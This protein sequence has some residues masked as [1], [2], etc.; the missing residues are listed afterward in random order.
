MAVNNS[1]GAFIATYQ[2]QLAHCPHRFS[3][4]DSYHTNDIGGETEAPKSLRSHSFC[5]LS[6]DNTHVSQA[7]SLG[8]EV[9]CRVLSYGFLA[10]VLLCVYDR[11]PHVAQAGIELVILPCQP[12]KSWDDRSNPAQP[13]HFLHVSFAI[14]SVNTTHFSHAVRT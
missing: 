7:P 6:D 9:L 10:L 1:E 2:C 14:F 8:S 11:V 13:H 5:V 4:R 12:P 3:R